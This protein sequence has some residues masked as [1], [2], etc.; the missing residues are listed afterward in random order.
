MGRGGGI[1]QK[2]EKK[3]MDVDNSVVIP[4]VRGEWREVEEGLRGKTV[5]DGHLTGV[6]NAQCR[7][8]MRCCGA[9]HPK[10]V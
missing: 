2:Q 10:P 6:V 9:V 8:Q 1:E 5:M 4:R 3:L 7:V